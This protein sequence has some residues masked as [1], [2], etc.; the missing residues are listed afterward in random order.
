MQFTGTGEQQ[1]QAVHPGR[2]S[3]ERQRKIQNIS[4][5]EA[6]NN[7][8]LSELPV[9]MDETLEISL[10]SKLELVDIAHIQCN[11]MSARV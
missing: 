4:V 1:Q 8:P 10:G 9:A 3:R 6:N 11:L 7:R 5:P 2:R